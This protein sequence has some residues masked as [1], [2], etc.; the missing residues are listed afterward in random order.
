[1]Q[2]YCFK[3][4]TKREMQDPRAVFASNG[5][6]AT[7]GVCPVCG[8]K[9]FK[10]GRTPAHEGLVLDE[11]TVVSKAKAELANKP[12]MVIVESPAKAR[13]VGR[14]LGKDYTVRASVGHVRDL[15]SN[16]MGV[17]IDD[18]FRPRYVIPAKRKEVVRDLP[19]DRPGPGGRG[20]LLAFAPGAQVGHRV[21]AG[22][23]R[24]VPRDHA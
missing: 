22:A 12:R 5:T 14:F 23:S 19:G 8:T 10:M 21:A 24:R 2:A 15:P 17:D 18:D 16:R 7:Q 1:M 9:M 20:N 11:R 6:P 3:C 13:T 4:K